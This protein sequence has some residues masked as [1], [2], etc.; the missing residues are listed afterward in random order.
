[1][2]NV[3]QTHLVANLQQ[4]EKMPFLKESLGIKSPQFYWE[5][6]IEIILPTVNKTFFFIS[7]CCL[8]VLFQKRSRIFLAPEQFGFLQSFPKI[9]FYN[10]SLLSKVVSLTNCS[11]H[12][13][14]VPKASIDYICLFRSVMGPNYC[15]VFFTYTAQHN[16]TQVFRLPA[17][18]TFRIGFYNS[19]NSKGWETLYSGSPPG[20]HQDSH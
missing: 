11:H 10:Y 14:A 8:Y 9:Q 1:M 4:P 3:L 13:R 5:M 18:V 20:L 17:R 16:R 7:C 19:K 6:L 15:G 2:P 12:L